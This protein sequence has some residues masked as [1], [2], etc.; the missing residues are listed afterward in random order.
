V[1]SFVRAAR[2]CARAS[3]S[4]VTRRSPFRLLR[5]TAASDERVRRVGCGVV[6]SRAPRRAP[7]RR[8]SGAA[9][10]L[11]A[12]KFYEW[13][14]EEVTFAQVRKD[15]ANRELGHYSLHLQV[16][17]ISSVAC[18]SRKG[19][20]PLT[21]PRVHLSLHPQTT[22]NVSLSMTIKRLLQA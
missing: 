4:V 14:G 17:Q 1:I 5:R 8:Y 20:P 15:V 13:A 6:A 3:S 2:S 11:P 16:G 10:S 19:S 9:R 18:R 22:Q 7:C 12:D 21:T